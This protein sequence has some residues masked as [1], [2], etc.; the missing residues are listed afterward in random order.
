MA[1]AS[2][3]AYSKEKTTSNHK[4]IHRAAGKGEKKCDLSKLEQL[5]NKVPNPF[6]ADQSG[7][8]TLYHYAA[9]GNFPE[10]V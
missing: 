6:I 5:L 1:A 3:W 10:I 7:N 8:W 4:L 2:R 9:K